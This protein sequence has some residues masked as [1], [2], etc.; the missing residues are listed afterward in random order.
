MTLPADVIEIHAVLMDAFVFPTGL[1][2]PNKSS[3]RTVHAARI[4]AGFCIVLFADE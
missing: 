1:L 3:E 2:I 4:P